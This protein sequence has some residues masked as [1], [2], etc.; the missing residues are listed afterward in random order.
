MGVLRVSR[1]S[2][3]HRTE[4][5]VTHMVS[6]QTS[7]FVR[8]KPPFTQDEWVPELKLTHGLDVLDVRPLRY[9]TTDTL[10]HEKVL[11]LINRETILYV[12]G[13]LSAHHNIVSLTKAT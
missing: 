11:R 2:F 9:W 13:A 4:A 6:P 1:A 12:G 7:G 5:L 3:L 10:T 8:N